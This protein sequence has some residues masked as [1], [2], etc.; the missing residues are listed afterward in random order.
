MFI[1][2]IAYESGTSHVWDSPLFLFVDTRGVYARL[3]KKHNLLGID[4]VFL[5]M[6]ENMNSSYNY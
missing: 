3:L 2:F 5:L 4:T 6:L 1:S